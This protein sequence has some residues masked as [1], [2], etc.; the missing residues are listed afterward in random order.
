MKDG[1]HSLKPRKKS[2][3]TEEEN[4]NTA[5]AEIERFVSRLGHA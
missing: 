2:G 5:I 3:V 1:D 4:W